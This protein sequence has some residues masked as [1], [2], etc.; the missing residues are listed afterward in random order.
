[1]RF[2]VADT[3]LIYKYANHVVEVSIRGLFLIQV[4]FSLINKQNI[5]KTF[6][7]ERTLLKQLTMFN[8]FKTDIFEIYT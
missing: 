8:I 1:M 3:I 2:F 4:N 5:T 6:N 7:K